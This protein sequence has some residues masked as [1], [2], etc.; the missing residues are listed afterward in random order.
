[1]K[2]KGSRIVV[3]SL[4]KEGVETLFCYIG[5]SV[6]PIFDALYIYGDSINRISPRHEQGGT[7]AA[8]G[9]ARSTG[10]PGVV[11]V[12]SGPGATNTLTGIATA[13]MDSIPLVI[14]TG[15]VSGKYIGTD[16]FQESDITGI[17]MPITKAN[18]LIKS[19]S[20]IAVTFKKAFHIANTGRK[21][22]VLID[23]PTDVQ[24]EECE[25]VYPDNIEIAGYRPDSKGKS[26]KIKKAMAL[27]RDSKRP[28]IISGGGIIS[29]GAVEELNQFA[30]NFGIPVV[31]TLMGYGCDPGNSSLYLGGLGMHGSLYGNYAVS[32]CDL[33]IALGCRFSDRILGDPQKFAPDAKIIHVDIDPAEIGKNI[34]ADLS[35]IGSAKTVLHEFNKNKSSKDYSKWLNMI[36]DYKKLHPLEYKPSKKM[37]PQYV[38]QKSAEIFDNDTIIVTDVGQHQMWVPQFFPINKSGSHLTSGGLGT[39]GFALPAAIGAKI[40]NPDKEVLMFSGDGGFQMNIQELTTIKKYNLNLKMIILDNAYLGMVRQWQQL[41][42]GGRYSQTDMNDNPDFVKVV[43]AFGIEAKR[44]NSKN[45]CIDALRELKLSKNAMLL[46][47]PVEREENV[48]PMVPAG[49]P[50]NEAVTEIKNN[51]HSRR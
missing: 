30:K 16:A 4:K 47:I 7:H 23:I 24:N 12:T 35:I 14:I 45:E 42:Y 48:L 32:N 6:I 36:L 33:L 17:T 13:Y 29:S 40:G 38:I 37:R 18:F 31:N 49:K 20:D 43:K 15:Q 27:I 51:D 2:M 46:H 11:L 19:A 44:V 1:M 22:P 34:S 10:K 25:F 39:M 5:G 28:L 41:L 21:G 8:D 3:E 50:L 9:Y 26:E